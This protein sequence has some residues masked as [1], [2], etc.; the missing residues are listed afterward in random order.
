M[1]HRFW[2]TWK[3]KLTASLLLSGMGW[4]TGR[5]SFSKDSHSTLYQSLHAWLRKGFCLQEKSQVQTEEKWLQHTLNFDFGLSS[6][7]WYVGELTGQIQ[8]VLSCGAE[9]DEDEHW[10]MSIKGGLTGGPTSVHQSSE[11]PCRVC[12]RQHQWRNGKNIH[13]SLGFQILLK[14]QHSL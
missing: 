4:Q 7:T 12:S 8:C 13:F 11:P 9:E 14:F 1:Q 10:R 5:L 3:L 6:G 2:K